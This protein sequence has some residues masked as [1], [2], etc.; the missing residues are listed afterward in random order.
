MIL[1]KKVADK[2]QDPLERTKYY[3]DI[4]TQQAKLNPESAIKTFK[5]AKETLDNFLV[6]AKPKNLNNIYHM[7]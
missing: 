4:A 2:I 3:F 5:L 6:R 7:L 1:A